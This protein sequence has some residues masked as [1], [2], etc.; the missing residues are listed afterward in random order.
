MMPENFS[1]KG[2]ASRMNKSFWRVK[3]LAEMTEQEWES[4][5]DGCGKCCL[6]KLEDE[7]TGE[8][9]YT[10]VACKLLDIEQCRCTQYRERCDLVADCLNLR[11]GFDQFHW[12]PAT[13]AYRLLAQGEDLP[14]WHPLVSGSGESVHDAGV[15]VRGYAIPESQ[16][17]DLTDHVIEGLD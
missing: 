16:V 1:R 10:S 17:E 6:Y 4:L 3:S 5:C 8:I 9:F 14:A 13:C 7:D 11:I 2:A 12:L 15:S